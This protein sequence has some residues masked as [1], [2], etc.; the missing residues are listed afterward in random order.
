VKDDRHT[1]G[2]GEGASATAATSLTL[3]DRVKGRE[4]GGWE[5]FCSLYSP[6]IRWWCSRRGVPASDVHDL[7]QDVFLTVLGRVEEFLHTGNRGSFRAWLRQITTYK[8]MEYGRRRKGEPPGEGGT[9]ARERL[10]LVAEPVPRE[11]EE[12]ER[13]LV[14]R[15]ALEQVRGKVEPK[16]YEAAT[17]T[18]LGEP[19][20]VVAA[21]LGMTAGAVHVA[22]SRVLKILREV[23]DEHLD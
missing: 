18:L 15:A 21:A 1:L 19:T 23:C 14:V 3:L 5:Q 13:A 20:A 10:A 16:T 6:L 8:V 2:G 4:A 22:K 9:D 17:R 7:E 11:E 12:T